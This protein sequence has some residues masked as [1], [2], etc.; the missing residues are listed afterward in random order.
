M[1]RAC[2]NGGAV[3][4]PWLKHQPVHPAMMPAM[5]GVAKR[6]D[7]THYVT[8]SWCHPNLAALVSGAGAWTGGGT[9]RCAGDLKCSSWESSCF[10]V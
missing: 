10:V 9:C 7:D 8:R 5:H 1:F 4:G 3:D 2:T 6:G